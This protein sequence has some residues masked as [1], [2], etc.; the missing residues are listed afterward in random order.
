MRTTIK[1]PKGAFQRSLILALQLVILWAISLEWVIAQDGIDRMIPF[2]PQQLKFTTHA[3]FPDAEAIVL[4]DVGTFSTVD[5]GNKWIGHTYRQVR[6]HILAE[7]EIDRGNVELYFYHVDGAENISRIKGRSYN[8]E[9]GKLVT[10]VLKRKQVFREKID[11]EYT[12]IRFS[13]PNVK[14]G[15]IIEYE[16]L[17]ARD[18]LFTLTPWYFQTDIPTLQS[19]YKVYLPQNSDYTYVVLGGNHDKFK[20]VGENNWKMEKLPGIKEEPYSSSIINYRSQIRFQLRGVNRGG[21]YKKVLDD[22]PSFTKKL[23][24]NQ[25]LGDR[26]KQKLT[27]DP[28]FWSEITAISE[29]RERMISIYNHVKNRMKWDGEHSY[30]SYRKTDKAYQENSGSSAEINFILIQLL[31]K[32]GIKVDPLLISTRNRLK[33]IKNYPLVSAFNHVIAYAIIDG[34]SFLLDATD[35]LRPYTLL[36]YEDLHHTGWL[37]KEKNPRWV[38]IPGKFPAISSV[39]VMGSIGED[40]FKAEFSGF[41]KGYYALNIRK[42]VEKTGKQAYAKTLAKEMESNDEGEVFQIENLSDIEEAIK[43]KYQIG[44]NEYVIDNGDRM[45]INPLFGYALEENPFLAK[46]RNY[47]VDFGHTFR[48]NYSFT[49]ILPDGY[50][51]ESLPESQRYVLPKN[52]GSFEYIV[53]E[54]EGKIQMRSSISMRE[55]LFVPEGY[56]YLRELY[57]KMISKQSEQWVLRKKS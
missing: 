43:W 29:P 41:A 37:L 2:N 48:E 7:S 49:F 35:P 25:Y 50:E 34:R 5:G 20:S 53:S 3:D 47:P 31:R 51:V 16:Y 21:E 30:F 11:E 40:G 12:R 45:Y 54:E 38:E 24:Q 19:D 9:N 27:V 55:T 57:D 15:T 6:I 8:L 56:F 39:S 4:A 52:V 32:A 28:T 44:E 26:L 1:K 46:E 33:P 36:A 42:E 17:K 14:V 13:L 23:L 18:N 22:W 10:S